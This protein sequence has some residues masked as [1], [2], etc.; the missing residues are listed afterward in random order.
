MLIA[1]F[2]PRSRIATTARRRVDEEGRAQLE[3]LDHVEGG[4]DVAPLHADNVPRAADRRRRVARLADAAAQR[5]SARWSSRR[6][7]T[8]RQTRI[9]AR[10]AQVRKVKR[11]HGGGRAAAR[12]A[13]TVGCGCASGAPR[14]A[15]DEPREGHVV[16]AAHLVE[17]A[18]L[19][20]VAQPAVELQ[21]HLRHCARRRVVGRR[22]VQRVLLNRR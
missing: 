16:A 3:Q 6:R 7:H 19:E 8:S 17:A 18:E 2:A 20:G 12:G 22:L 21:H 9:I 1:R 5:G 13:P 15:V 10:G 14:G 11:T 4:G